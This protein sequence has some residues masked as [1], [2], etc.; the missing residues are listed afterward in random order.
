ML[1]Q[2]SSSSTADSDGGGPLS[3]C[4]AATNA[5]CT[6]FDDCNPNG[7]ACG[8]HCVVDDTLHEGRCMA[9]QPTCGELANVSCNTSEQCNVGDGCGRTCVFDSTLHEGRCM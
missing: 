9:G 7:Q 6:T 3:A 5:T 8:T 4:A 1:C 2:T